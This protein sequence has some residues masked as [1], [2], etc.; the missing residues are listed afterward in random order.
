[1]SEAEKQD[2]KEKKE[3]TKTNKNK[4]KNKKQKTDR[5]TD[6]Q[7]K[8]NKENKNLTA[9]FSQEHTPMC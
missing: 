2:I 9:V 4:N 5:Q 7:T 6:R 8:I 1:V 3:K